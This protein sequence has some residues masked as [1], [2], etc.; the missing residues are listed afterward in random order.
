MDVNAHKPD[1]LARRL[2]RLGIVTILGLS[3]VACVGCGSSEKTI[4]YEVLRQ[5]EHKKLG[6]GLEILVDEAA[7]KEDVMTLAKSL[8]RKYEGNYTAIC[9]FDSREA[10]RRRLDESYPEK[11]L[12]RHWLV[13]MLG[14]DAPKIVWDGE[15]RDH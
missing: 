8:Q 3:L 15:G 6:T 5:W 11:K 13:N 12:R 10:W 4:P 9:I 2:H 1:D 7:S 14:I